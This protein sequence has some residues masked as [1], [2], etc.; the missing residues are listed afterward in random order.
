MPFSKANLIL[1]AFDLFKVGQHNRVHANELASHQFTQNGLP[2]VVL[3]ATAERKR[4]VY[5]VIFYLDR[6]IDIRPLQ[7]N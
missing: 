7:T 3:R 4:N 2:I 5:D 1:I 6:Y